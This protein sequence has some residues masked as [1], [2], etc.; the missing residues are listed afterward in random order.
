M[1]RIP[2]LIIIFYDQFT[3][4]F[5]EECTEVTDD[6]INSLV[7]WDILRTCKNQRG[8]GK[9]NIR[10]CVEN[11]FKPHWQDWSAWAMCSSTCNNPKHMKVIISKNMKV[12]LQKTFQKNLIGRENMSKLLKIISDTDKEIIHS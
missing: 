12:F 9:D 4:C 7:M 11:G 1:L 5:Q 10:R 2:F 3:P 8:A 6:P